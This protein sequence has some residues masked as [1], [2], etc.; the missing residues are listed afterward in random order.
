MALPL[1]ALA[2]VFVTVALVC[3][4]SFQSLLLR[5]SSIRLSLNMQDSKPVVRIG[6]RGSPLAL[7]Q[8]YEA[9]RLL[10]LH[11]P[12]LAKEG[13]IEIRKIMTKV[14]TLVCIICN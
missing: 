7:A 6:T 14:T 9:K 5:R 13:A 2:V 8:A 1:L 11:F 12:E 10:G 3:V 4:N